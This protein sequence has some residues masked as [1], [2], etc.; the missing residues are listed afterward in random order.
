MSRQRSPRRRPR[1]GAGI[2]PTESLLAALGEAV[3]APY[4]ALVAQRAEGSDGAGTAENVWLLRLVLGQLGSDPG[5]VTYQGDV[6]APEDAEA[7]FGMASGAV[8]EGAQ[9]IGGGFLLVAGLP[10][11]TDEGFWL[12]W[13]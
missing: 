1:G 7:M 12:T 4:A 11:A 6:V 10:V 13:P 3:E 2:V 5:A 9:D 8:P